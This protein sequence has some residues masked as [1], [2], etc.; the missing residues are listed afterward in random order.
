MIVVD[1]NTIAYLYL[2]TEHSLAVEQLLIQEPQWAAPS[3]WR[4]ELR[5][6]L[7]VYLKRN[8]LDLTTVCAIQEQAESLMYN[9]EYETRSQQVLALAQQSGCSAYDCEFVALAQFLEVP[10]VTADK[11]L[12]KAFPEVCI[13]TQQFLEAGREL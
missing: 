3:L 8:L 1:T 6:V 2:P 10:M 4:S 9:H 7:A 11:Q 5:N 12:L 13:T